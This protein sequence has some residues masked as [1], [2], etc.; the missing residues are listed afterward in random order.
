MIATLCEKGCS[1]I[2]EHIKNIFLDGELDEIINSELNGGLND[3][4]NDGLKSL[5]NLIKNS[6]G[7]KAKEAASLL[8]GRSINTIE[9][10]IKE[11]IDNNLI[12]RK[13]SKKTGG[14]YAK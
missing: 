9:K 13:G 2:T 12:E 11:L 14:Y 1:A 6:P 3:G 7:I 5:L 4:L 8:S 10:Q